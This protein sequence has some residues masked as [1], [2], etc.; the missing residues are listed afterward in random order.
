MRAGTAF[1]VRDELS[2]GVSRGNAPQPHLVDS[3]CDYTKPGR[4]SPGARLSPAP[5][6][7]WRRFFRRPFLAR[8]AHDP[9]L[10]LQARVEAWERCARIPGCDKSV[11]RQDA[12]GRVI[13]WSDFGDRFSR[14]GWEV[15]TLAPTGVLNRALARRRLVAVHWRGLLGETLRDDPFLGRR[16]A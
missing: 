9:F 6:G 13:R 10:I 11:W 8:I 16:A 4:R 1:V 15:M 5:S 7:G 14:Y 12:A 3:L 2:Q